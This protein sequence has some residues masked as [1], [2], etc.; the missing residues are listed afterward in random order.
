MNK[1]KMQKKIKI[2]AV[3]VFAV[4]FILI[5]S[6]AHTRMLN[7]KNEEKLKASYMAE[8]T[9]RH[10]KSQLSQY[11]VKS[12]ILKKMIES[13]EE[14]NDENFAKWAKYLQ[15]DQGILKAVELAPNGVVSQIY[16]LKGNERAMGLI[17]LNIRNVSWRLHLQGTVESIR[18]PDRLNLRRAE[19]EHCFLN[20]F[21]RLIGM[22]MKRFGDSR[23]WCSTGKNL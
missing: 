23:F 2:K 17:C 4:A 20:R 10:I 13:G 3:I 8:S 16:L 15:D 5:N 7:Q 12:N 9:V 6:I 22:E 11:L 19:S 21:I 18:S 1:E 14:V